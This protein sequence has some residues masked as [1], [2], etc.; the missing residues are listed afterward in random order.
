MSLVKVE[1]HQY[2]D[3]IIFF[4]EKVIQI[5]NEAIEV[6]VFFLFFLY[7]FILFRFLRRIKK[8]FLERLVLKFVLPQQDR[9]MSTFYGTCLYFFQSQCPQPNHPI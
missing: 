9:E 2:F 6:G 5:W 8:N 7:D 3:T 1:N 4:L